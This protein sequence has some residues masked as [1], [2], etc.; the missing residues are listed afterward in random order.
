MVAFVFNDFPRFFL[1]LIDMFIISA[2]ISNYVVDSRLLRA[3]R[4][5][6][7]VDGSGFAQILTVTSQKRSVFS[8][9]IQTSAQVKHFHVHPALIC[10]STNDCTC[11]TMMNHDNTEKVS[12]FRTVLNKCVNLIF[13]YTST[14][15]YR[16][17]TGQLN[18][19]G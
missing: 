7:L 6:P 5:K 1:A 19:P 11:N 8:V 10:D 2:P 4:V 16:Y 13:S 3:F 12:V 18:T 14:I 9:D 15:D 17:N